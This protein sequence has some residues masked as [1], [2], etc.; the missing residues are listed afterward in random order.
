MFS[1]T[2]SPY[3]DSTPTVPAKDNGTYVVPERFFDLPVR[4][5][6]SSEYASTIIVNNVTGSTVLFPPLSEFVKYNLCS[7]FPSVP[8]PAPSSSRLSE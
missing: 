3:C 7:S 2:G 6:L 4:P 8:D 1:G 5:F